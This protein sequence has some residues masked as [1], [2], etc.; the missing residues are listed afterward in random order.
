MK[1]FYLRDNR[2]Q[3]VACVASDLVLFNGG[4]NVK[5]ALSTHNSLD[6]FVKSTLRNIAIGRL[7][8]TPDLDNFVYSLDVNTSGE[9]IKAQVLKHLIK[10]RDKTM[11]GEVI[12]RTP[13]GKAYRAA[14]KWLRE[15][16]KKQD[17]EGK[18]AT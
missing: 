9:S 18:A 13:P 2:N 4:A 6:K 10:Q 11:G 14:K 16:K 1:I 5:Y 8:T 7:K 12:K 3:L 17:T 15:A